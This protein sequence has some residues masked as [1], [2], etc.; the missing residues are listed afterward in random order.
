M[1]WPDPFSDTSEISSR[2]TFWLNFMIIG[3]KMWPIEY[4]EGFSKIWTCNMTHFKPVRDFIKTNILTTFNDNRTEIVGSRV[5]I[6]FFWP[7][8]QVFDLIWAIFKLV[9]DFIKTN[10]PIK[11]HDNQTE[12][13]ASRAYTRQKVEYARWMTYKG[14]RTRRYHNSSF[15]ALR[16]QVN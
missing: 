7:S 13:V 3:L 9:R 4:T 6:G 2:H 12:N 1:T 15:C 8:D 10:I 14:R 16:A 5:Y 11:F